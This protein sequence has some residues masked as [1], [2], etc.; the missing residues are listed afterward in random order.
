MFIPDPGSEFFPS[1]IPDLR[2]QIPDPGSRVKKNPRSRIR[3]HIR[4]KEFSLS[5]VT[6]KLF[7]SSRK[8]DPGCRV[9]NPDPY[10]DPN[11]HGSGFRR[12]KMNHKNRKKSRIFMFQ[13][14]DVLF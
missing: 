11:P 14:L 8:Y 12:A 6:K 13:F 7:L 1:R 9:P 3:I 2:S 5:I 10:P 4:I